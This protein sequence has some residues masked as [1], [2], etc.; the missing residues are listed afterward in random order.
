MSQKTW[1]VQWTITIEKDEAVTPEEA[2][3]AA[4]QYR[5]REDSI[6]T[7]FTV[8]DDEKPKGR[9]KKV[10]LLEVWEA[11]EQQKSNHK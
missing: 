4:W 6:A 11:E 9:W 3:Q 8:K 7:V 2:A 5:N 1:T 10:D